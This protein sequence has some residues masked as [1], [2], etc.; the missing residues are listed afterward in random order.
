MLMLFYTQLFVSE[1]KQIAIMAEEKSPAE[2][3][4]RLFAINR[5]EMRISM[6]NINY[7]LKEV[8]DG[9]LI[10]LHSKKEVTVNI[11]D[12]LYITMNRNIADV[13]TLDDNIYHIRTTL[14]NIKQE[15]EDRF[16]IVHRST[17]VSAIAVYKVS[18]RIYLSNGE[19]IDYVIRK[20]KAIKEE[21]SE[22]QKKII[23]SFSE[24]NVPK[25]YE[26]YRNY[27][28]SYEHMPFA[29]ADIEMIFND[30][31]HAVDWIFRYGNREL[32][33]L[34]KIPLDDLIGKS[35][36]SLFSNMDSKWLRSY[37]QATLYGKK[38]EIIDYSPEIDR[39]LKVICF[40]TF[41]GHCGCIL[42]NIEEIEFARN[43]NDAEKALMLYFGK[44]PE[45][46]G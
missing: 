27:Y 19:A 33:R 8:K 42:F 16:V 24:D 38:L 21:I 40:P 13:H 32:A 10:L 9:S 14:E 20:K 2:I 11:N 44:M 43:S 31:F 4:F 39:Y 22:K 36:G 1:R 29:F 28:K 7:S 26:E 3:S 25:S 45:R 12:I 41:K 15:L 5:S 18:D 35:F 17:M 30:E 46:H 37:E 34:E 23:G 6:K